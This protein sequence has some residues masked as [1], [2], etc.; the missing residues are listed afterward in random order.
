[1]NGIF[2]ERIHLITLQDCVDAKQ[3]VKKQKIIISAITGVMILAGGAA[4]LGGETSVAKI[5]E[6]FDEKDFW[7]GFTS[8]SYQLRFDGLVVLFTIPLMVGLFLVAK[9]GVKHAE[10]LMV[11]ISGILLVTPFLTGFTNQTNQPYRF[12]PFV[13]F[14][15]IGVGVLLSKRQV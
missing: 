6:E 12:V 15:A 13:V 5:Q 2:G 7:L 1:M 9:S 14:F 11:L 10:S 8:F 3:S 4:A